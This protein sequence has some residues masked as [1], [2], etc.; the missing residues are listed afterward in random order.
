[1]VSEANRLNYNQLFTVV[2]MRIN[3]VKRTE[4]YY[5]PTMHQSP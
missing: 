4:T 3:Q 5:W 1:M 2:D